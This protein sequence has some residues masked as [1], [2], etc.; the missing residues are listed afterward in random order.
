MNLAYGAVQKIVR[1]Q[2]YGLV[3]QE[4]AISNFYYVG[5]NTVFQI[6]TYEKQRG[7]YCP[8]GVVQVGGM[9]YFIH[10]SG[11]FVTDG[12]SVEPIGHDQVDNTWLDDV[13]TQYLSN[14]RGSHDV[15]NKC[16][17]WTY[18]SLTS[19]LLGGFVVCDKVI[20]YNYAD[21]R[22]AMGM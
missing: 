18:P 8:N 13:N 15:A 22:W 5:G 20:V 2:L 3:F 19:T 21:K 6:N 16:I 4:N 10:S 14:V 17:W 12:A 7:C 11:F 1:G 9:A